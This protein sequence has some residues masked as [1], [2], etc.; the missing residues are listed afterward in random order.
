VFS[1]DGRTLASAGDTGGR[2][3]A[4]VWDVASGAPVFT[5]P[6]GTSYLT[7]VAFSPDGTRL[8][9]LSSEG[10]SVWEVAKREEIRALR[11]ADVDRAL[12]D[13]AGTRLAVTERRATVVVLDVPGGKR[14][15]TI[16]P[17]NFRITAMAFAGGGRALAIATE[18]GLV[19]LWDP[20]TGHPTTP[21]FD[22]GRGT[23]VQHLAASPDGAFLATSG[24]DGRVRIWDA[25]TGE[26]LTPPFPH[27]GVVHAVFDPAGPRLVSVGGDAVREWDVSTDETAGSDAVLQAEAEVLAGRRIDATGAV[28]TL[29]VGRLREAWAKLNR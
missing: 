26:P 11:V 29:P 17:D 24:T 12:F 16:R 15:A 7:G 21:P 13:P 8:L 27:P 23:V 20:S 9:T 28:S 2:H 4:I 6:H 22:H 1:P 10:L 18:S 3:A 5:L 19:R 14:V 25:R